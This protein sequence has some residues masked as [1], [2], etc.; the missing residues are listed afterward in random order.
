MQL[1]LQSHNPKENPFKSSQASTLNFLKILSWDIKYKGRLNKVLL[2][3]VSLPF[4]E[5]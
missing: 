2:I 3:N 5:I 1:I 4:L